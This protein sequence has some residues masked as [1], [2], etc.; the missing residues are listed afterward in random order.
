MERFWFL[1]RVLVLWPG[2]VRRFCHIF[3]DPQDKRRAPRQF[4][5]ARCA[6][7]LVCR[8]GCTL[9]NQCSSFLL[10]GAW[11]RGNKKDDHPY[12]PAAT[13]NALPTSPSALPT[14]PSALACQ[15]LRTS[16]PEAPMGTAF[17]LQLPP[18][19]FRK[20]SVPGGSGR[21]RRRRR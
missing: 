2:G 10:Y 18:L 21:R 1:F 8:K 11:V 15:S 9:L 4:M 17:D 20:S 14:S 5:S 7:L 12:S 19:R 3:L 16:E 6:V 13:S